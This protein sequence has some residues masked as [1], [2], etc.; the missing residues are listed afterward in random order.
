VH[1]VLSAVWP[2]IFAAK[3]AKR[4]NGLGFSGSGMSRPTRNS[5]PSCLTEQAISAWIWFRE[6]TDS[7]LRARAAAL[8]AEDGLSTARDSVEKTRLKIQ[9]QLE[10]TMQEVQEGCQRCK[11]VEVQSRR[12]VQLR[13]L[14]PLMQRAKRLR[15]QLANSQKQVTLLELQID[16]FENGRV[17]KQ[18][19]E[20]LKKS[21][22]VMK[23]VGV[24]SSESTKIDDLMGEFEEQIQ[25]QRDL[26]DTLDA[27]GILGGMREPD[28]T[29]LSESDDELLRELMTL[30]GEPPLPETQKPASLTNS[31][32]DEPPPPNAR[33]R[34]QDP[35]AP[36]V[37]APVLPFDTLHSTTNAHPSTLG[38]D[39][40]ADSVHESLEL[41]AP[42]G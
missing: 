25:E 17:Q 29:S 21:V 24:P 30:M 32:R 23:T 42:T 13:Q 10:D 5:R 7:T 36:T 41:V 16:A 26:S 28:A 2:Y 22:E 1:F 18:L 11:R 3:D 35:P 19:T 27:G 9:A 20:S 14:I 37:H 34:V 38:S 8:L 40:L 33:E 12:M 4:Q 31:M 6:K 39:E 15:I